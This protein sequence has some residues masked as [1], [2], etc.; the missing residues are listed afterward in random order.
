MNYVVD[1]TADE[2]IM[3]INQ[4]I[5]YDPDA[6]YGIQGALFQTEL[7][8]LDS[9]GKKRIQVWINSIGGSV[10]EGMS[11]FNA[12]L[13][14]KT[15]VDTYN[16][17]IA[18]SIA[19]VIF[20]AGR[21]R[22]MA[23][24]ALM[25]I[26]SPSGSDDK[27][28]MDA[29][30]GSLTTMLTAKSKIDEQHVKYLMDRTTWLTASECY[31]KGFCTE[32]E[33]TNVQNQKR[34]PVGNDTMAM[35]KVGDTILNSLIPNTNNNSTMNIAK[36]TM[37]LALNDAATEDNIV[38]AINGIEN[39]AT[40]AEAALNT[41]NSTVNRLTAEVA[42]VQ[43]KLNAANTKSIADLAAKDDALKLVK[44][45]LQAMK[46]D[47]EN[48]EKAALKVKAETMVKGFADSGRIKNEATVI[49]K[50]TNLAV[51][52]FDGTKEMLDA[53]PLNKIS[54]KIVDKIEIGNQEVLQKMGTAEYKMWQIANKAKLAEKA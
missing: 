49:L 48:A 38:S 23:D 50:W 30:A 40:T 18:A 9:M 42:D 27:K 1:A 47:K 8:Q 7:L 26:H 6:G 24:Y 2:P 31:E 41:A 28:G 14:S 51:A 3:L 29:I 22:C 11:I 15:P 12:I 54:N 19:G 44:D 46:T 4:H 35:W 45:E 20:M 33:N 21:K 52:D 34:M 39:R 36:I 10:M 25:M 13:K 5:G 43:N 16:C 17:G 32:I 53:I 37:R